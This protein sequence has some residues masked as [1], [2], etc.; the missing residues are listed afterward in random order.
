MS[1]SRRAQRSCPRTGVRRLRAGD[2]GRAGAA[3]RARGPAGDIAEGRGRGPCLEDC[4]HRPDQAKPGGG[5]AQPGARLWLGDGQPADYWPQVFGELVQHKLPGAYQ[6]L[7]TMDRPDQLVA[8]SDLSR[9]LGVV[10]QKGAAGAAKEAAPSETKK[11]L[12]DALDTELDDFKRSTGLQ[13]GGEKLYNTVKDGARVLAEYYGYRG[14]SRT[15]RW[16]HA[17]DGII[18]NKYDFGQLGNTDVRVP[19]GHSARCVAAPP[20]TSRR[21]SNPDELGPVPMRDPTL[22]RVMKPTRPRRSGWTP[23][24]SGGWANNRDDSGLVLMGKFRDGAEA[25]VVRAD[26]SQ[27]VLKFDNVPAIVGAAPM[28]VPTSP[29]DIGARPGHSLMAGSGSTAATRSA[30]KRSPT[31][32][33]MRCRRRAG[34]V[35]APCR[36]AASPRARRRASSA[37]PE[38][39]PPRRGSSAAASSAAPRPSSSPNRRSTPRLSTASS[40]YRVSPSSTARCRARWRRIHLRPQ[41]RRDHA[42]GRHQPA[43]R[44]HP[45]GR[46]RAGYRQPPGRLRSIRSTSLSGSSR[47]SARRVQPW[48]L[49]ALPGGRRWPPRL[50]SPSGSAPLLRLGRVAR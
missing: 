35:L 50:A 34:Q 14:Q 47:S 39:S 10:A 23:S 1:R 29:E 24:A 6:L 37:R 17:V 21:A 43:R 2:A 12:E 33:S 7:A 38:T 11:G 46:R 22:A 42:P 41:A 20:T 16:R 25:P 45:D 49:Q 27:V 48:L 32:A 36:G 30:T 31:W 28:P 40:A 15:K 9:A 8:A 5:D 44:R 4:R 26:G 19:E 3:R 13:Q 18:R